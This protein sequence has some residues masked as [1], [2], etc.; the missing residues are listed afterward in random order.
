MKAE[1]VFNNGVS[2]TLDMPASSF[3]METIAGK[4]SLKTSDIFSINSLGS[5]NLLTV[6]LRNGERW[7]V[8]DKDI[9]GAVLG[10]S[11][12]AT[13]T[14]NGT[15]LRS[16][17]ILTAP[18]QT[19]IF[20]FG[21]KVLFKDGSLA[22]IDPSNVELPVALEVG[23]ANIPLGSVS[24]IKFVIPRDEDVPDSVFIRLASGHVFQIPWNS[25]KNGFTA[26]SVSG[27][28]IRIL[29]T[30]ILGILPISSDSAGEIN[31]TSD[32]L[33]RLEG[34]DGSESI[35]HM[36]LQIW[37]FKTDIGTL[38]LPSPVVS[39][40][41]ISQA[42]RGRSQIKTIFGETFFGR[43]DFNRLYISSEEESIETSLTKTFSLVA[44]KPATP[45]TVPRR[46][47]IFHLTDGSSILGYPCS[48][49]IAL[50]TPDGAPVEFQQDN[51][52]TRTQTDDFMLAPVTGSEIICRPLSKRFEVSLVINGAK[53]N[54]DW[55]DL[56]QIEYASQIRPNIESENAPNISAGPVT[57]TV[58]PLPESSPEKMPGAA[59]VQKEP[60]P[61]VFATESGTG[62]T[63]TPVPEG[64]EE[65]DNTESTITLPMPWGDMVIETNRIIA[66]HTQPQGLTVVIQTDSSDFILADTSSRTVRKTMETLLEQR[67]PESATGAIPFR[68]SMRARNENEITVRLRRG[69]VITGVLL[70][71]HVPFSSVENGDE[72]Q[73]VPANTVKK[74]MRTGENTLQY[75]IDRG[76]LTGKPNRHKLM[77]AS[78]INNTPVELRMNE[79]DAMVRGNAPLPPPVRCVAGLP[80]ALSDEIFIKG[81]TFRQGSGETGIPDEA[82]FISV[83]LSPFLLDATEVT[84]ARFAAFIDDTGYKTTAEEGGSII[85][86]IN[87][88]FMQM[89]DD[90]V[91]CVSWT[92]AAE[93]CNWRSKQCNLTSVYRIDRKGAVSTDRSSN[94]Y[95]LPT[96]SE[97]E[98]AAGGARQTVYP[99]GNSAPLSEDATLPANFMQKEGER[100][101][102]WR[103]TNPVKEFPADSEGVYGMSGNV[104]EWCEDWYFNRAYDALKNRAP[105][106]PCIQETDFPGLTHRVMRGGSFRN[107]TDMLRA[108]SRGNGLPQAYAPHV[109]FRCAR[110]VE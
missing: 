3:R 33:F 83:T 49:P 51:T 37:T 110:N 63:V 72:R 54:I 91:V 21:Y 78:A 36:P 94:G 66:I 62:S 2:S 88:G 67:P 68:A 17:S 70:D 90:P 82:P 52:L 69:D 11:T 9:L 24:A 96:E 77:F 60:T 5:N 19:P 26:E 16:V 38:S 10:K 104:W 47:A 23:D 61:D 106:N 30:E 13:M 71:E 84:R 95:R 65:Q 59:I 46:A 15:T 53:V 42:W 39:E 25:R 41:S 100:D 34:T 1:I 103:W 40:F 105:F 48:L 50:E 56:R 57:K 73:G 29:Y 55:S 45:L 99:W 109:G 85:T 86:W 18:Q 81:G 22:I 20:N 32:E 27:N 35:C 14:E 89:P 74:M 76:T 101:D 98:F 6:T 64:K 75:F 108:A 80:P 12:G 44:R 92:D 31:S 28:N 4:L 58:K 43:L 93:F 87:P 97:W 102:G 107:S 7:C 79:I 8:N